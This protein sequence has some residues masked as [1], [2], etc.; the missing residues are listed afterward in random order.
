MPPLPQAVIDKSEFVN[1]DLLLPNREPVLNDEYT[2]KV[3]RGSSPSV[4]LVPKNQT[5]PK[6]VDFNSWMVAWN[7][8]L[9]CL[10]LFFPSRTQE[11]IW[12]Q[13]IIADFASQ[14][15][16]LSWSQYDQMFWYQLAFNSELSWQFV[17]DDLY[18]RYLRG[19][20]TLNVCYSAGILA[21]SP[22]CALLVLCLLRHP[23]ATWQPCEWARIPQN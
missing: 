20:P 7:N 11:L 9:R 18:N 14:Y 23:A 1:F 17:D 2:S 6:V 21:T 19:A 12:Y 13:A 8:F 16:F 22:V 4:S 15:T 10:S 3:I 5:K